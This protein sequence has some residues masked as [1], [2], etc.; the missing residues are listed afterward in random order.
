M[1]EVGSFL[2]ELVKTW[3]YYL[4]RWGILYVRGVSFTILHS[5]VYKQLMIN[6]NEIIK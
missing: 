5:T 3:R 6:E 2:P 1:C 4:I